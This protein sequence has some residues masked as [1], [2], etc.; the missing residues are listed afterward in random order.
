MML[1][2][3]ERLPRISSSRTSLNR[4]GAVIEF[5][6]QPALH[7]KSIADIGDVAV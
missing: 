7:G 2:Q 5:P 4:A 3:K 6:Q 1:H